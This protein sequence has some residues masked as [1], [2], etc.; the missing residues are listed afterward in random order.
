MDEDTLKKIMEVYGDMRH[1][2]ELL[3]AN[4]KSITD[5]ILQRYPEA[6]KEIEEAREELEGKLKE[7]EESVKSYRKILDSAIEQF[8]ATAPI[9]DKL[10]IKT[11]LL[12]ISFTN[13][14]GSYDAKALDELVKAGKTELL[15]YRRDEGVST[16]VDLN[17]M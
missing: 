4:S 3:E 17:K 1:H 6:R 11:P 10:V 8:A 5:N 15:K 14:G 2:V 12:K 7:A 9:A 13:K 16:R